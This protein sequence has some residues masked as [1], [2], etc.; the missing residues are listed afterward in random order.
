MSWLSQTFAVFTGKVV[1]Q[2]LS[3]SYIE[4]FERI[5]KSAAERS[6]AKLIA[7]IKK[8]A[9]SDNEP[10]R[11][12][13]KVVSPRVKVRDWAKTTHCFAILNVNDPAKE[14]FQYSQ[15]VVNVVQ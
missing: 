5:K 12:R 13:V 2:Y 1:N 7:D 8:E 9:A 4:S 6:S 14:E 10:A 11:K 15:F 3:N